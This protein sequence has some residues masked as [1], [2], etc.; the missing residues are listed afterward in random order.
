MDRE[1]EGAGLLQRIHQRL[2]LCEVAEDGVDIGLGYGDG[3]NFFV[4]E[5]KY[6]TVVFFAEHADLFQIDNIFPV[7]SD[8]T[9]VLEAVF[10]GLETAS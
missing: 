7:T 5:V 2:L 6:V 3:R 4:A 9:T 1:L 10:N 8:Q